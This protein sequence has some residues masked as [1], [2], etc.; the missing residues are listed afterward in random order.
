M[1]STEYVSKTRVE[2][3][4]ALLYKSLCDWQ[5]SNFDPILFETICWNCFL[6]CGT[7][8]YSNFNFSVCNLLQ[9]QNFVYIFFIVIRFTI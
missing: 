4:E 2:P 8:F 9:L 6:S 1:A 3:I 5:S 7:F